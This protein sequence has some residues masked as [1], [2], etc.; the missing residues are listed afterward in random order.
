MP[1]DLFLALEQAGG[2][3]LFRADEV[4]DRYGLITS[5]ADPRTNPDGL[6]VGIVR[7]EVPSGR[8]KG[9]WIGVS[10]AACHSS[11][12]RY[13]GKRIRVEG[14]SNHAFDFVGYISSLDEAL[15]ATKADAAKFDRT[16]AR[17]K[18]TGDGPRAALRASLD[19]AS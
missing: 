6:P 12:L 14:G 2:T 9:D 13:Q 1:Y 17:M 8:W 18:V 15:A 7:S 4:S 16:A 5:P 11:E 3:G 10:C 19:E